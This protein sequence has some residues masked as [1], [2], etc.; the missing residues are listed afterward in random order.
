MFDAFYAHS[1]QGMV[2]D[3]KAC[4]ADRRKGGKSKWARGGEEQEGEGTA[5]KDAIVY[6]IFFVHQMN[7]KILI[8][9]I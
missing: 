9:Q 3:S 7:I 8:G 2:V 5:R 4:V 1:M 6:F